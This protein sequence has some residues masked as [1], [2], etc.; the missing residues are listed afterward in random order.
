MVKEEKFADGWPRVL[1]MRTVQKMAPRGFSF[2]GSIRFNGWKVCICYKRDPL[3]TKRKRETEGLKC[4][5]KGCRPPSRGFWHIDEMKRLNV[6]DYFQLI[7]GDPGRQEIIRLVDAGAP[8]PASSDEAYAQ[9]VP[10]GGVQERP[11]ALRDAR[12]DAPEVGGEGTDGHHDRRHARDVS[13]R[14]EVFAVRGRV[15]VL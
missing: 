5:T 10:D 14:E 13:L 15:R 7:G 2:P 6:L 8:R 4:E 1:N 3:S 11:E 12:P 9:A